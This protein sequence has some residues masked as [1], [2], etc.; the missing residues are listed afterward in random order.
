M[1]V[2]VIL[3]MKVVRYL[4]LVKE[5]DMVEAIPQAYVYYLFRGTI[6]AFTSEL[7]TY[8]I[9]RL[10]TFGDNCELKGVHKDFTKAKA[11]GL[12]IVLLKQVQNHKDHTHHAT[13]TTGR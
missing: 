3:I 8:S 9:S 2:S 10:F 5:T 7:T 4:M 12:I 6:P 13:S 1:S 11:S